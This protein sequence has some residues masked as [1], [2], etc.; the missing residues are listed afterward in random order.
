MSQVRLLLDFR[1]IALLVALWVLVT[2]CDEPQR[3]RTTGRDGTDYVA[4]GAAAAAFMPVAG[5]YGGELRLATSFEPVTLNP[6]GADD[7]FVREASALWCEGLVRV[8]GGSGEVVPGLAE[9]WE[10]S[11]NGTAYTFHIR[12]GMRWSDG[13]ALTAYDVAFTLSHFVL[14]EGRFGAAHRRLLAGKGRD[15]AIGVPDSITLT[16]RLSSP[17]YCVPRLMVFPVLPEHRLGGHVEKGTVA[18]ALSVHVTPDSVVSCGPFAYARY[19]PGQRI[20]FRRNPHYWRVDQAANRL[21]YLDSVAYR[22]A[23]EENAKLVKFTSGETD[24]LAARGQDYA[25]LREREGLGQFVMHCLGP[26]RTAT[27]L[28]F[29]QNDR[30]DSATQTPFVKPVRL[31]WFRDQNF[32]R[33]VAVALDREA[34]VADILDSAGFVHCSPVGLPQSGSGAQAT[35][36]GPADSATAARL[37]S[38]AGF[39]DTDGDG[40]V[41]DADGNAVRFSLM[42]NTGNDTRAKIAEKVRGDLARIGLGVTVETV[43]HAVLVSKLTS[44]PY[45]WEAALVGLALPAEDCYA[46]HVW[47]S[48]GSLHI[49][50]PS[51]STPATPWETRLDSLLLAGL[52]EA[53]TGVRTQLRC[54]WQ[55]IV[56]EFSPMV[57]TVLPE[58][59]L[60]ISS[61]FGN[62]NPSPEGGLLHNV[63]ELYVQDVSPTRVAQALSAES[64]DSSDVLRGRVS[65]EPS[66][67]SSS[68]GAP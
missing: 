63:D 51:R 19:V 58:R 4:I 33:A 1:R 2:G 20:V 32:R 6:F 8:D 36:C 44:A 62:V 24:Y 26:S 42:T 18:S 35:A 54:E 14:R 34:M 66:G 55:E 57:S 47:H 67:D 11:G 53:D 13:V 17:L 65:P 31:K 25:P 38:E 49:W 21:P 60:C 39:R 52:R 30:S 48:S 45:G 37:L 46:L 9:R 16:I 68:S 22:T 41:E 64:A 5:R 15:L 29:N 10:V 50:D 12:P 40:V 56:R 3:V 23:V 7:P 59:I 28:T 43:E 61:R 27:V